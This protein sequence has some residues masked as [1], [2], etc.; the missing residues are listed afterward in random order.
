MD[1]EQAKKIIM[2]GFYTV[3]SYGEGDVFKG[4][5]ECANVAEEAYVNSLICILANIQLSLK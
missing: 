5:S 3:L 4:P 2:E 1:E